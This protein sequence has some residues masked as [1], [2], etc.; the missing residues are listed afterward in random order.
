LSFAGASLSAVPQRAFDHV[1]VDLLALALFLVSNEEPDVAND[2]G[3]DAGRV[4][5]WFA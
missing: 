2:V 3:G 1:R 5:H 4:A